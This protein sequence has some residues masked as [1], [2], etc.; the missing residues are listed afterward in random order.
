MEIFNS[1][2]PGHGDVRGQRIAFTYT[3]FVEIRNKE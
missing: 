2:V 3:G 1:V